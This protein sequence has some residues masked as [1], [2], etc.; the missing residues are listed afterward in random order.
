MDTDTEMQDVSDDFVTFVIYYKPKTAPLVVKEVLEGWPFVLKMPDIQIS[1]DNE[2]IATAKPWIEFFDNGWRL[3]RTDQFNTKVTPGQRL[4]LRLMPLTLRM[5]IKDEDCLGLEHELQLQRIPT[6]YNHAVGPSN[7]DLRM[8]YPKPRPNRKGVAHCLAAL[9]ATCTPL[10]AKPAGPRRAGPRLRSGTA[11]LP[12]FKR[13]PDAVK[14]MGQTWPREYHLCDVV[15]GLAALIADDGND[16]RLNRQDFSFVFDTADYN[17]VIA[18]EHMKF[19]SDPAVRGIATKFA[20]YGQISKGSY[21]AFLYACSQEGLFVNHHA[22]K[23]RLIYE[24]KSRT[25]TP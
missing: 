20:S 6:S 14:P 4:L 5:G 22:T 15:R 3:V 25:T 21:K 24:A 1:L 19:L 11:R 18:Q 9:A 16:L 8:N 7:Q 10:T 23:M 13:I 12:Q 17:W 2:P